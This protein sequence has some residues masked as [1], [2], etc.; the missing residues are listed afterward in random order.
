MVGSTAHVRATDRP[1][2]AARA[3]LLDRHLAYLGR[4]ARNLTSSPDAAKDLV[5]S[6]AE[7]ALI[8]ELPFPTDG[9]AD[10]G[11]ERAWLVRVMKNQFID[12]VRRAHNRRVSLDA[13]PELVAPEPP[14]P[15]PWEHLGTEDVRRAVAG[16]PAKFRDV[17]VAFHFDGLDYAQIASRL[18]LK[19]RTVGTRLMRA[20]QKV[21]AALVASR[22][23]GDLES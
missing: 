1:P 2:D 13:A 15:V 3:A 6:V 19:R 12:D 4:V 17:F 16:L 7:R 21:R 22:E 8:A 14:H 11:R 5:Q 18:S 9:S 10:L 23:G 20:R